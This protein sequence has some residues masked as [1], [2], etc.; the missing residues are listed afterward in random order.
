VIPSSVIAPAPTSGAGAGTAPSDNP[1]SSAAVAAGGLSLGMMTMTAGAEFLQQPN[2]DDVFPELLAV[3]FS[4]SHTEASFDDI[5]A[6]SPAYD[7]DDET[8]T[9]I[10]IDNATPTANCGKFATRLVNLADEV[11]FCISNAINLVRA[12]DG[13]MAEAASDLDLNLGADAP[14]NGADA[15]EEDAKLAAIQTVEYPHMLTTSGPAEETD[16]LVAEHRNRPVPPPAATIE[17]AAT[18]ARDQPPA[19]RN[20]P[21][22]R[23]TT[24]EKDEAAATRA[25]GSRTL[26]RKG[27]WTCNS[28]GESNPT[29]ERTCGGCGAGSWD[30]ICTPAWNC[31]VCTSS[32][33][34][35]STTKCN[36][37]NAPRVGFEAPSTNTE[38]M[39]PLETLVEAANGRSQSTTVAPLVF[40]APTAIAAPA[41]PSSS[42]F[43]FGAHMSTADRS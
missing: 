43:V 36:C 9:A 17:D 39:A 10:F 8:G 40:Q 4:E 14:I 5:T 18:V 33:F 31:T 37:C 11:R 28:C 2:A 20:N 29:I 13:N 16:V 21:A 22:A 35:D 26:V 27:H 38:V 24:E 1:S 19:P 32:H 15:M 34:D 12:A 3:S 41:A 25:A 42:T 7:D 30:N 23:L 6:M